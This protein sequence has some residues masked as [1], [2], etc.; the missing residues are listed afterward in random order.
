MFKKVQDLD[1]NAAELLMAAEKYNLQKLKAMAE[2][3]LC[4]TLKLDSVV[5]LAAYASI[6]NGHSVVAAATKMIVDNFVQ[7]I[8]QPEWTDFV[9]K[10][11]NLLVNIHKKLAQKTPSIFSAHRQLEPGP[12]PLVDSND[13]FT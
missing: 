5:W 7:V 12:R 9:K 6:H 2:M 11:P 10:Y 8:E 13:F 3:S 1:S 4:K